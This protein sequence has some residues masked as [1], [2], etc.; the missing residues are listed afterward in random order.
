MRNND[1]QSVIAA[2]GRSQEDVERL[3]KWAKELVEVLDLRLAEARQELVQRSG[4]VTPETKVVADLYAR[5]ENEAIPLAADTTVRFI[6][7][8]EEKG[9][10]LDVHI[11]DKELKVSAGNTLAVF[12]GGS[13][14]IYVSP[15]R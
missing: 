11:V 4:K 13:N 15:Q 3:P 1:V 10:Y 14:T 7:G 12:P 8:D 5:T 9:E 2:R 6:T